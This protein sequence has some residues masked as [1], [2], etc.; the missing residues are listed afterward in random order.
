MALAHG[1]IRRCRTR[2][3]RHAREVERRRRGSLEGV[4]KALTDHGCGPVARFTG[5]PRWLELHR[6]RVCEGVGKACVALDCVGIA[7]S[8][9]GRGGHEGKEVKGAGS[10]SR[11][12]LLRPC[13]IV[14]R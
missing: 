9:G 12:L 11:S 1:R 5:H 2:G 3:R 10:F 6:F 4:E 7:R 13:V 8:S 14:A